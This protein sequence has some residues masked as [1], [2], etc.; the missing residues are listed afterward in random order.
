MSEPDPRFLRTR[1]IVFTLAL[2]SFVLSFFHRTAPAAIAGELTQA[3][4]IGGAILGSLSAT[5]FY[6]YLLL[7]IPV[8][9]LADTIGVR[10][11]LTWGSGVAAIGSLAFALAPTWEIAALGRA[12]TAAGV[13]VAFLAVLKIAVDWFS[14]RQFASLSGVL[15]LSGNLGAVASG[16]PLAWLAS[17]TSWRVAFVGLGLLSLALGIA[18]WRYVRDRPTE[19]GFAPPDDHPPGPPQAIDWKRALVAVLRNPATWPG[20]LLN[21]GIAGGFLAWAGLWGVPYLVEVHGMS[22]NLAAQH[23]SLLLLAVAF[24]ALAVGVMSDRLRRRKSILVVYTALYTASW[25]PWLAGWMPPVALS[26]TWFALTGAVIPGFILVIS[27]AKES[28]PRAHSGI[29]TGVANV[30]IF[31][32]AGILQPVIGA[33]LDAG[34]AAGNV[35]DAWQLALWTLFAVSAFGLAMSALVRETGRR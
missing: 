30:G 17:V 14:A 13:S 5:Y 23:T 11:L 35:A 29:A 27:V 33:L 26:L 32:G 18:S 31:I 15:L 16:A 19:L 20:F 34:R 21:F 4:S 24:G 8:G 3:F 9:V 22:R 2:A 6:V 25:L 7:Q 10:K 12:I 1:R 28:N